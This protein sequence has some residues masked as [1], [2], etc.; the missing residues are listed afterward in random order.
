MAHDIANI[1]WNG[2]IKVFLFCVGVGNWSWSGK[3]AFIWILNMWSWLYLPSANEL[4]L[5][6]CHCHCRNLPLRCSISLVYSRAE[7]GGKSKH[8][9]ILWLSQVEI[10]LRRMENRIEWNNRIETSFLPFYLHQSYVNSCVMWSDLRCVML[11][12]SSVFRIP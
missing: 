9:E 7:A 6:S 10:I 1:K 2:W 8:T 12:C 11:I 5:L 4:T 3:K